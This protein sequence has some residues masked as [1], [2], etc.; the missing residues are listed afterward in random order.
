MTTASVVPTGPSPGA[1]GAPGKAKISGLA[2]ASLVAGI[3][4]LCTAGLGGIAGLIL[5]IVALRRIGRSGG[6]LRGRGLAIA[7]L[8]VSVCTV[9]V[10]MLAA[11]VVGVLLLSP[12]LKEM[13]V[14]KIGSTTIILET[15]KPPEDLQSTRLSG[16]SV[17]GSLTWEDAERLKDLPNVARIVPVKHMHMEGQFGERKMELLVVGTDSGWF[18]V[19]NENINA[20]RVFGEEEARNAARVCLLTESG[21]RKL[22]ADVGLQVRLHKVVFVVVGIVKSEK[23]AGPIQALDWEIDAYIPLTTM[24]RLGYNGSPQDSSSDARMKREVGH[25]L[26]KVDTVENVEATAASAELILMQFHKKGDYRITAP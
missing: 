6:A 15:I 16:Q 21:A 17:G 10:W 11:V 7:G 25:I 19:V 23:V 1:A 20:G 13:Q 14:R 22:Q 5:G 9:L 8:I 24:Y 2:I 26:I 18:N 12:R 4:G 3:F